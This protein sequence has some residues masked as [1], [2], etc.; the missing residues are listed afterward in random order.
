LSRATI[1]PL[2]RI[3]AHHEDDRNCLGCR[4]SGKCRGIVHT[5]QHGNLA[6]D[7]IGGERRQSIALTIGK[8]V[9]DRNIL[10][11]DIAGFGQ[12]TAKCGE[13]FRQRIARCIE[14]SPDQRRR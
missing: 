1:P 4:F 12:T 9:L 11:F 6:V 7:Q 14:Q 10:P 8:A 5:N 2:H 13:R 3:D